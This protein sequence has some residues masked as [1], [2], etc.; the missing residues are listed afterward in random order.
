MQAQLSSPDFTRI[1]IGVGHPGDKT[2]VANY[3][4]RDFP[5]ADG[6]WLETLLD[7]IARSAGKLANG[8]TERF[9]T[10]VAQALT[11]L[12]AG[13]KTT[14]RTQDQNQTQS[15]AR[16]EAPPARPRRSGGPPSTRSSAPLASRDAARTT[17][18]TGAPS[19]RDLARIAAAKKNKPSR[20]IKKGLQAPPAEPAPP[21]P[22]E[23][24]ASPDQTA[25]N[26]LAAR[27]KR[28]FSGENKDK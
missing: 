16:P 26:A 1:R 22:A 17:S 10:D 28:W 24:A 20:K 27:L 25:G 7:A 3:V 5:K 2:Q 6:E 18:R 11:T 19:Q 21:P 9:Q 12:R 8:E 15:G 4:L 13:N 14:D 23:T